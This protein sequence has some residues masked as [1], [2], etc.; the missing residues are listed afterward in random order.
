MNR[1]RNEEALLEFM[2]G[3]EDTPLRISSQ[4]TRRLPNYLFFIFDE[5]TE[6]MRSSTSGANQSF[7]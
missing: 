1:Y 3:I 2:R 5:G 4:E 6:I 7:F